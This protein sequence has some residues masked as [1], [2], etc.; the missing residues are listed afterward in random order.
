MILVDGHPETLSSRDGLAFDLFGLGDYAG[1]ADVL[2]DGHSLADDHPMALWAGRYAAMA[3]RRAGAPQAR[4]LAERNVMLFRQKFGDLNVE[5]LAATVSLANCARADGDLDAAHRLLERAVARYHA[6]LGDEHP[7][8]L[9]AAAGLAG[10]VRATGRHAEART[11]DAEAFG[12]L[13]RSV[14]ADHPF[15]LACANG[16]AADLYAV[17]EAQHA[18]E[19]AADTLVRSRVVRGADHPDTLACAWNVALDAGDDTA[20]Q[21]ALTALKKV[22]GE[23]NPMVDLASSDRRLETDIDPPPL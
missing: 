7:F 13:S 11:I 8:T 1:A 6:V 15:T 3:A 4:E 20:K 19:I 21:Q 5:T 12:G 23:Q 16:L 10:V 2:A 14:G 18:R 9:A 22:Y 17:G